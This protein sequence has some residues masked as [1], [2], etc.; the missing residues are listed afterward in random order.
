MFCKNCGKDIVGTK[1]CLYCGYDTEK[2]KHSPEIVDN[3][4]AIAGTNDQVK[5]SSKECPNCHKAV[6][7]TAKFCTRCGTKLEQVVV[8][9]HNESPVVKEKETK[10]DSYDYWTSLEKTSNLSSKEVISEWKKKE[11]LGRI[12]S[13]W[14]TI[15]IIVI[16][17]MYVVLNLKTTNLT[18]EINEL[19]KN[20]SSIFGHFIGNAE[21][22]KEKVNEIFNYI[23]VFLILAF[24]IGVTNQ[25]MNVIS[26]RS[27][28]EFIKTG[29]YD[30][31]EIVKSSSTKKFNKKLSEAGLYLDNNKGKTYYS[32]ILTI[33]LTSGTIFMIY[34]FGWLYNSTFKEIMYQSI[35][36]NDDYVEDIAYD[37]LESLGYA[38][39]III[40]IG[41]ILS[42]IS[43]V[44]WAKHRSLRESNLYMTQKQQ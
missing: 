35:I 25:F 37:Y 16:L 41:L 23:N 17:V 3:I 5:E 11:K 38:T 34:V 33:N 18:K 1:K 8:E 40:I 28:A 31:R 7:A 42:I 32:Q 43:I 2:E 9:N 36:E 19:V 30:Y 6:E 29:N 22:I 44:L 26:V 10:I 14:K 12:S 20:S 21:I 39:F 4:V 27:L 13:Y 24:I 15:F